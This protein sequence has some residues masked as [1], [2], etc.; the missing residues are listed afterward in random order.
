MPIVPLGIAGAE[1]IMRT[2]KGFIPRFGR[3]TIVVGPPLV[4]EARASGAV[5]R[6]KVDVLTGEL[7]E[8]LQAVLDAAYEM[9]TGASTASLG[10]DA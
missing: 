4:P 9:R 3:V 10:E 5:A 7:S 6:D 8:A 2:H 1:E